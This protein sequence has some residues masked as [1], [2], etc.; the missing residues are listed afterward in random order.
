MADIENIAVSAVMAEVAGAEFLKSYIASKDT[1][2]SLDGYICGY[3]KKG[4]A[5]KNEKGRAPVQIKG[6]ESTAANLLQERISYSVDVADMKAFKRECG[7]IFFVVLFDKE[8][9]SHTRIYYNPLLPYDINEILKDKEEQETVTIYLKPFPKGKE[10]EDTVLTFIDN[11]LKQSSIISQ[12]KYKNYSIEEI[13][14]EKSLKNPISFNIGYTSIQ[15]KDGDSGLSYFFNHDFYLYLKGEF[16]I[17]IPAQHIHHLEMI[18]SEYSCSLCVGNTEYFDKCSV[19]I[20]KGRTVYGFYSTKAREEKRNQTDVIIQEAN[21]DGER[22]RSI[23]DSTNSTIEAIDLEKY[24]FVIELFDEKDELGR[25]KSNFTYHL[26]G[27]LAEKINTAR[28]V[29]DLIQKK[30]YSLN[31]HKDNWNPPADELKKFNLKDIEE[32]LKLW[33]EI[34]KALN[35]VGCKETLRFEKFTDIDEKRLYCF[36]ESVLYKRTITFHEA[37]PELATYQ[38]GNLSLMLLFEKQKDGSYLIKK[39]PDRVL[40][41]RVEDDQGNI[42]PTSFYTIFGPDSYETISNLDLESCVKSITAF[43]NNIHFERANMS[44]LHML[45]AYDNTGKAKLLEAALRIAKW[46]VEK[47]APDRTISLM[48]FYQCLK[49]KGLF[50]EDESNS[51]KELM[52]DQENP[53]TLA[54]CYLLL[55]DSEEAAKEIK[56]LDKD[57]R[58]FFLKYPI[59]RF[60]DYEVKKGLQDD[61]KV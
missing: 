10:M 39:V 3:S 35:I 40:N 44:L 34:Q 11:R 36:K 25:S 57:R 2:P 1:G 61:Q 43:E 31:G 58:D 32:S 9:P 59:M 54:G 18:H 46:M 49:R 29:I 16:D 55:D 45:T 14:N 23:K 37:I 13:F 48:N 51:V 4:Y 60:M 26:A 30:S 19:T 50:S 7:T 53:E 5:K 12:D 33:E 6:K 41:C 8:D 24:P 22:E 42:Y 21:S 27:N 56:T 52:K 15:G 38:I 17:L 28:F 20:L 47:E